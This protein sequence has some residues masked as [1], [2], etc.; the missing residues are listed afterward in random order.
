VRGTH[1]EQEA[2]AAA[3]LDVF[4]MG[5]I[6]RAKRTRVNF[7]FTCMIWSAELGVR[8]P[9]GGNH[10]PSLL[11]LAERSSFFQSQAVA[12]SRGALA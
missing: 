8:L 2:A 9:A 1:A 5:H 11:T 3:M 12:S 7:A 10:F 6:C 4:D